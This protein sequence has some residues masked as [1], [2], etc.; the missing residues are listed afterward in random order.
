MS[1]IHVNVGVAVD[2]AQL[3]TYID[4]A[5][6]IAG[7]L[8]TLTGRPDLAAQMARADAFIT[9]DWFLAMVVNLL[10]IPDHLRPAAVAQMVA[11]IPSGD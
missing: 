9:Q 10:A 2:P 5:F 6:K 7:S 8:A 11:S 1:D 3:K 4:E